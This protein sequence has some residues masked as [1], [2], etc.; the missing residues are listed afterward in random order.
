MMACNLKVQTCLP[1]RREGQRATQLITYAHDLSRHIQQ[2]SCY[3]QCCHRLSCCDVHFGGAPEVS[4]LNSGQLH[5][6]VRLVAQRGS[7]CV[8]TT[9]QS[10]AGCWICNDWSVLGCCVATCLP[11]LTSSGKR[12]CE[13][14]AAQVG[15]VQL[16]Q[17]GAAL[18]YDTTQPSV[19]K[20][21]QQHL[22]AVKVSCTTRISLNDCKHGTMH[23]GL[24]SLRQQNRLS[25]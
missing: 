6:N 13:G 2:G 12:V 16:G 25:S 19:Q 24:G 8:D 4:Y 10:E 22:V 7:S 15:G 23:W 18:T 1:T 11:S 5:V 3:W 21:L 14:Q 17:I 20:W 9:A